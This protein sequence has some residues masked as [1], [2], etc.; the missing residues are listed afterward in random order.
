MAFKKK[1]EEKTL[2]VDAAM[3]AMGRK[4]LVMNETECDD[5]LVRDV[6]ER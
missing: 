5:D 1:L 2:D 3:Q 6:S 4:V